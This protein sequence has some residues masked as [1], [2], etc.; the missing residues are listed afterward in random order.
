MPPLIRG[1]KACLNA[2]AG[3]RPSTAQARARALCKS[4]F[5][6]STSGLVGL[7][8]S[9]QLCVQTHVLQGQAQATSVVVTFSVS[10]KPCLTKGSSRSLRSLGLAKAS[11]L[12]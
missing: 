12:T 4:A 11:P 10:F 8:R 7:R 5:S 1:L 2:R 9:A 3:C 6:E